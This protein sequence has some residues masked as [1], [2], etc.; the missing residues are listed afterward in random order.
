MAFSTLQV[1]LLSYK[2]D[3]ARREAENTRLSLEKSLAVA[4]QA[5]VRDIKAQK[6]AEAKQ[7]YRAFF[8]GD[9][10]LQEK[11]KDYTEI[12]DFEDAMDKIAAEAQSQIDELTFWETQKDAQIA[13]NS[14]V[15]EEDNAW[16]ESL[17]S[18]ITSNIQNDFN[19][20]LNS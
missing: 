19:F 2:S 17:K 15:I 11:Y 18:M 5:D 14:A 13:T 10:E 16:I 3:K 9:E 1:S 6:E 4:D 8:E 12:P 7:E 20:G